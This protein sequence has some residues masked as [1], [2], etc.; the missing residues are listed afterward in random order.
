[1][2]GGL[3]AAT[4][5][6]VLFSISPGQILRRLALLYAGVVATCVVVLVWYSQYLSW[7]EALQN[8]S[9]FPPFRIWTELSGLLGSVTSGP[10]DGGTGALSSIRQSNQGFRTTLVNIGEA[11]LLSAPFVLAALVAAFVLLGRCMP[12]WEA[13]RRLTDPT[14]AGITIALAWL[15]SFALL[16]GHFALKRGFFQFYFREFIPPM[17]L[18]LAWTLCGAL[19]RLGYERYAVLSVGLE[20]PALTGVFFVERALGGSG[21]I[22]GVLAAAGIGWLVG[23]TSFHNKRRATGYLAGVAV[24]LAALVLLGQGPRA[25]TLDSPTSWIWLAAGVAAV[26]GLLRISAASVDRLRFRAFLMTASLSALATAVSTFGSERIGPAFDSVWPPRVL[27]QVVDVVN[28]H[29]DPQDAVLS[30]AVIWEFEAGRKTFANVTH[31]AAMRDN[32]SQ[33]APRQVLDQLQTNPPRIVILDG[34]TEQTYL[35]R[36]PLLSEMLETDYE[37]IAEVEGG[38]YYPVRVFLRTDTDH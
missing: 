14:F 25:G 26:G 13:R 3:L 36:V 31:P 4:L 28:T 27:E 37:I 8:Q 34:D 15:M 29:S 35:R 19:Q 16:Y 20:L 21:V 38:R 1:M 24:L 11:T 17:A 22:F 7:G 9:L 30:G 5:I 2:L 12:L 6:L 18:L 23:G 32:L 33:E 10:T